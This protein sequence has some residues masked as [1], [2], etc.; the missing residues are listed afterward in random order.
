MGGAEC[1]RQEIQPGVFLAESVLWVR[2]HYQG[3]A[4]ASTECT[5]I[6][7]NAEK[8]GFWVQRC[9]GVHYHIGK[10]AQNAV[11]HIQG[12]QGGKELTDICDSVTVAK[13]LNMTVEDIM[14]SPDPKDK[15]SGQ[16]LLEQRAD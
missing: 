11:V 5:T 13:T 14:S 1:Y 2:W 3:D 6:C 15:K 4:I 12:L 8:F 9:P 16:R 10:Y 7:I